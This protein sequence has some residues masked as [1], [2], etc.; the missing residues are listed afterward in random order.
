M[1]HILASATSFSATSTF[2]T[3]DQV[4]IVLN[5][6]MIE[7]GKIGQAKHH[8]ENRQDTYLRQSSS[9][10]SYQEPYLPPSWLTPTLKFQN[11]CHF[12]TQLCVF[13]QFSAPGR[14]VAFVKNKI[15]WPC[16]ITAV[17]LELGQM[18]K[19]ALKKIQSMFLRTPSS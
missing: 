3:S 11:L 1:S 7:N 19:K 18:L 10:D 15:V 13:V 4:P 5:R 12:Q 16:D 6:S 8:I 17:A 2:M 14:F 9:Q